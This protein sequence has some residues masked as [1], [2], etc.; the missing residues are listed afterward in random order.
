MFNQAQQLGQQQNAQAQQ[1]F[2]PYQQMGNSALSMLYQRLGMQPPQQPKQG[3]GTGQMPMMPPPGW[4][5][6]PPPMP[7]GGQMMP[8][9]QGRFGQPN[10]GQQP[11]MGMPSGPQNAGMPFMGPSLMPPQQGQR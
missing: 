5:Q 2:N 6:G 11:N 4:Q 9:Q 3:M 7:M 8:Q 1:A 10:F